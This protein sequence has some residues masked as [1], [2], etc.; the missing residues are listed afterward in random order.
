MKLAID[1]AKKAQG[2]THPNPA[3]GCV[4]VNKGRIVGLGYH[5]RA[6]E[7]HAEII[8]LRMA[9]EKAK[10]GEMYVTL[11]PCSHHGKT[12]PCTEAIIKY[13]IKSVYIGI[14]DPNP[15]VHG[16]EYLK[17]KGIKVV[18]DILKEECFEINK[19]FFTYIL[20]D[21]PY[22]TLKVAQSIDGS[23][24]T[25]EGDS[26]WISSFESR[27]YAHRLRAT[28]TAIMVGAN[29]VIKDNP[30][31]TVRYIK[32]KRQ[33]IRI[34]ID[35]S[36]KTDPSSKIYDTATAPTIIIASSSNPEKEKIFESKGVEVVH[37]KRKG[38]F[39]DAKELMR[40]LVNRGIVH[41]LVEG[42]PYLHRFFIEEGI[43]DRMI[44]FTA[45]ILIGGMHLVLKGIRSIKNAYSLNLLSVKRIGDDTVIEL[46]SKDH[47][48][49]DQ[50]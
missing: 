26:K 31:L 23:V 32:T 44:V 41:L 24:A 25:E 38:E 49:P 14:E 1:L 35:P 29:T 47:L 39:V 36:L 34:V 11:E 21:K 3:V 33:P 28:S 20:K 46:R 10:G 43:Y 4:I 30:E 5:K 8:A 15:L 18:K 6:G 12:P 19:D 48:K 22:I 17:S 42:G 2:A 9:G 45:P 40:F 37:I 27:R 7:P 13:G 50:L 16:S